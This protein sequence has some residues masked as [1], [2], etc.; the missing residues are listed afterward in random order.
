MTRFD[1][2]D[3]FSYYPRNV[4]LPNKVEKMLLKQ[5]EVHDNNSSELENLDQ[6]LK[7]S[8]GFF[9]KDIKPLLIKRATNTELLIKHDE[10]TTADINHQNR[11]KCSKLFNTD[12]YKNGRT[13]FR[14]CYYHYAIE[15]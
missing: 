10:Y 12:N 8:H 5:N 11:S 13:S 14:S 2:G 4:N 15:Y 6:I 1:Y 9:K 3:S 7:K